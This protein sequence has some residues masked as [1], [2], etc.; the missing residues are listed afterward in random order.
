M[1]VQDINDV[2]VRI[3]PFMAKLVGAPYSPGRQPQVSAMFSVQYS[4]A[5][6]LLRGRFAVDDTL[7]AAATDPEA[8][9]LASRVRVEVDA[10]Q[11]GKFVPATV[12]V[13]TAS[14]GTLEETVTQLAQVDLR[15]K[16]LACLQAGARP[17]THDVSLR[18]AARI[19]A[20]DTVPDM[21]EFLS[22]AP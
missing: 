15:S 18:F 9:A 10:A 7:P 4:V 21:G 13:R 3:T 6:V 12:R 8:C 19:A 20:I 22:E 1:R 16:A 2:S 14:G 5:N 11:A 17:M